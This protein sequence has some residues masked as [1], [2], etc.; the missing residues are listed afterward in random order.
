MKIPIAALLLITALFSDLHVGETFPN[1]TLVNQFDE[2]TKVQ[3]KDT[4]TLI[5]SFRKEGKVTVITLKN[6]TITFIEFV[7]AKELD[8]VLNR[9][10]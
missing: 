9:V 6:N 3:T 4:T 5:L 1:L 8:K 10:F 7:E 2:K